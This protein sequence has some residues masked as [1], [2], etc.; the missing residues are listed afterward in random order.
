[1]CEKMRLL[2]ATFQFS[3]KRP[4]KKQEKGKKGESPC[5]AYENHLLPWD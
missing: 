2:S 1:M 4:P 3:E 5:P